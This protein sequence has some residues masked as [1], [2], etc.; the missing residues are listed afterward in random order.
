LKKKLLI[1][2]RWYLPATK[3]GGTVRSILALVNG[4]KEYFDITILTSDRDLG[5]NIP[6]E[7]IE[8]DRLIDSNGISIAYLSKLDVNSIEKYINIVNPDTIYI[9]SF[10][11]IMTQGVM[12]LKLFGR[13][14]SKIV[15]APRGELAEGALSIKATKKKI[16]LFIYKLFNISKGV[17]FHATSKE[18][19][20]DINRIFPYNKIEIIQ[21]AKEE[22]NNSYSLPLKEI[23]SLKIIFLS[24]VAVVK[25]LDYAL[26]ILR[27]Y[28]FNGFI[29]FD[30]YGPL[31]DKRYW[32]KCENIISIINESQK[33]IKVSYKGF[34]EPDNISNT[35]SNY[36]LFFMPTK[37]ENFGHAI[38]EAM[39]VGLIPLISNK[40]PWQN[41]KNI[42][43]GFS[44]DLN[45]KESFATALNQILLLNNKKFLEVSINVKSYINKKVN[46]KKTLSEY[47]EFFL[48][49]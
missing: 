48:Q 33:N 10:F 49:Y 32:A 22:T 19:Y 45:N 36:H 13:I 28:T 34:I 24:R 1:I 6:Y 9:N 29:E 35:L 18:D 30:I 31:E 27:D 15:V 44:L 46:N 3:S 7:N 41:L 12:F 25:N 37:G 11:D 23:N 21:N 14:K 5:S 20:M 16:Y 42:D 17:I 38:V 40:T 4:L 2:T 43:A 39:K 26:E 8:F 47:L